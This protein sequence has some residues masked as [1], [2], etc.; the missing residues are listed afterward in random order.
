M[1]DQS[2]ID[3]I[4]KQIYKIHEESGLYDD[5]L[6]NVLFKFTNAY[7]SLFLDEM[8]L[9]ISKS[10][11]GQLLNPEEFN[12][13]YDLLRHA[14]RA[15]IKFSFESCK[16][17]SF[18]QAITNNDKLDY[19]KELEETINFNYIRNTI[20]RYRLH[21][22]SVSINGDVLHFVHK[23]GDRSLIYDLYSRAFSNMIPGGKDSK[24]DYDVFN[25]NLELVNQSLRK[26]EFQSKKIFKPSKHILLPMIDKLMSYFLRDFD[27]EIGYLKGKDY[28]L[29]DYLLAYSY[30]AAIGFFKTAYL[31]SLRGENDLVNQPCIVYPKDRLIS[32][33]VDTTGMSEEIAKKAMQDMVY[34]YEFHKDKNIIYQPVFEFE[35][36]YICSCNLLFH[37]YVVD[38]IMKYF[39]I[40]GTNLADLTSYHKY[41]S[42]KMNDRMAFNLPSMYDNLKTFKNCILRFGNEPQSEIDLIVFDENTKSACLIELK[43][44]TPVDNDED[45]INK[46]KRINKAIQSRLVRDK[47]VLDNLKIFYKQNNIPNEYLEYSFSSLLITD[48]YTGGVNINE[49]IKVIDEALFYNILQIHQGNLKEAVQSINNSEFFRMLEDKIGTKTKANTYCYKNIIVEVNY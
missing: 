6:E 36:Y 18:K 23:K 49:K 33:I 9:S 34:D 5:S 15:C 22:Y 16:A 37:S 8:R 42:D 45:A 3:E 47:R 24:D 41:M 30:L 10:R 20:D 19:Q 26:Q 38:K 40:R 21:K 12:R 48:S 2:K 29:G 13:N 25:L 4:I 27:Y 7:D 14:Y 44:Y 11:K 43:N 35:D 31:L 32:D 46:E 28:Y 1:S 17:G 39:D